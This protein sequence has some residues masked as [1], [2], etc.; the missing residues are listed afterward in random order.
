M[1]P[2]GHSAPD[3]PQFQA[4]IPMGPT[5]M[6]WWIASP[7]ELHGDVVFNFDTPLGILAFRLTAEDA[8]K[9]GGSVYNA[10]KTGKTKLHLPPGLLDRMGP[11]PPAG[12]MPEQLPPGQ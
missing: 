10:G 1:N 8:M 9:F 12:D 2:N 6:S 7:P 11:P 3:T 5:P 4:R